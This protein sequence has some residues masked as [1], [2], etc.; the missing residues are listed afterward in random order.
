MSIDFTAAVR[1]G[2][3]VSVFADCEEKEGEEN[4]C[5][6]PFWGIDAL[7]RIVDFQPINLLT[8]RLSRAFLAHQT[9]IA[10]RLACYLR[11][12]IPGLTL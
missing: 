11:S 2:G 3:N 12:N 10:P 7:E 9:G 8:R 1:Y 6:C 4:R 5:I